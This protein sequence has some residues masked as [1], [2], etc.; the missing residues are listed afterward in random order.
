[1]SAYHSGNSLVPTQ[2]AHDT[3]YADRRRQGMVRLGRLG[4]FYFYDPEAGEFEVDD[5]KL[6]PETAPSR[7]WRNKDPG[8]QLID[9][10]SAVLAAQGGSFAELLAAHRDEAGEEPAAS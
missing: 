10:L 5:I 9:A 3:H 7:L 8:C 4:I 6:A 1:M 2:R